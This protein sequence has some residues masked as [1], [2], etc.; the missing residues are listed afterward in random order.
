MRKFIA[1][2][3]YSV[4]VLMLLSSCFLWFDAYKELLAAVNLFGLTGSE[5]HHWQIGLAEERSHIYMCGTLSWFV[6]MIFVTIGLIQFI[7]QE[8]A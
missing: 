3:A 7:K 6:V 5:Y 8:R 1:Y 4:C 2:F